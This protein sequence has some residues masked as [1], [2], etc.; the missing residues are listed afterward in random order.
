MTSIRY[1]DPILINQIAA[2]EV[3]E[4]PASVV[5]ELVEN[6]IDAGA[7]R[8]DVILRDA[9]KAEITIKD[10]AGGMNADELKLAV[11]RHATSKIPDNDL[12]NIASLGFRGE[13]LASIGAIARLSIHSKMKEESHGWSIQVSGGHMD[14]ISPSTKISQH[15]TSVEVLDLFFA[16]PARLKFLK[17]NA[18]EMAA[19][20][21]ILHRLALSHPNIAFTLTH[22]QKNVFTFE[23]GSLEERIH[24]VLGQEFRENV[25]SVDRSYQDMH[26]TGLTSIPTFNHSQTNQQ[27]FFVNHRPVKDKLLQMAFKIAYQDFIPTGRH[28]ACCIFL[29]LPR[30]LVD[31][32]VHPAKTEVRFQRAGDVRDFVISSLKAQLDLP[33]HTTSTHLSTAAITSFERHIQAT[34]AANLSS[35]SLTR[36]NY[37]PTRS[38]SSPQAAA[39]VREMYAPQKVEELAYPYLN[40]N[41]VMQ[42]QEVNQQASMNINEQNYPLGHARAQ[43]FDAYIISQTSD[44]FFLVDQHAAAERLTYESLKQGLRA[45][46]IAQQPL[47]IPEIVKLN[48]A[49]REILL[50]NKETLK[51]LGLTLQAFGSDEV[52]IQAV[53]VLLRDVDVKQLITDI[54]GDLLE[55]DTSTVLEEKLLERLS[56]IACH[57]SIRFGRKLSLEEMNALLRQIEAVPAADQCNHGR[58]SYIKLNR[59]DLERLFERA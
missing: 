13:A 30:E 14:A 24:Q 39:V 45:N 34:H 46:T 51:T 25:I 2:G 41:T 56:T 6:A 49:A 52:M 7:T 58:P 48:G 21:D 53:P 37:T 28:A 54:A 50:E 29:H 22:N 19:N 59:S 16:T 31:M 15:G 5:K 27:Y 8:I 35:P 32:N 11:A 44:A 36:S 10:N 23:A 12:F 38:F 9:G 1:L 57:G 3:V 17:S 4:R 43:L 33:R 26:L 42:P 47:L 20:I 40:L 18:T 55:Q